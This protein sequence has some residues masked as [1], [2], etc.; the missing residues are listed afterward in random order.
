MSFIQFKNKGGD[1]VG[2]PAMWFNLS[3]DAQ[4]LTMRIVFVLCCSFIPAK[5]TNKWKCCLPVFARF[6]LRFTRSKRLSKQSLSNYL[7]YFF[8]LLSLAYLYAN[9]F[10]IL[11]I[12]CGYMRCTSWLWF[13]GFD[14]CC[15]FKVP[16]KW[17]IFNGWS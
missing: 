10:Y 17:V 14:A 5:F 4:Q 16:W 6:W 7:L 1:T 11:R 9:F 3:S 15:P 2:T 13:A 8:F 12:I